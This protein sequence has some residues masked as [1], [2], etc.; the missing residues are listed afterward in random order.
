MPGQFTKKGTTFLSRLVG[1]SAGLT[2]ACVTQAHRCSPGVGEVEQTG[3]ENESPIL[4][5]HRTSPTKDSALMVQF[6]I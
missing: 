1:L 5:R 3:S 4:K 2:S 6:F